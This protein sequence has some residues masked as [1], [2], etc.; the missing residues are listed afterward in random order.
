MRKNSFT[1]IEL[2]VV[3][4]I[5]AILAGMLL[6]A[7][8]KARDKARQATCTSNIK[9]LNL[10]LSMYNG[11][12][13]DR[14]PLWYNNVSANKIY[15]MTRLVHAGYVT[16][17]AILCC[18][19]QDSAGPTYG[20]NAFIANVA[21]VQKTGLTAD[22]FTFSYMSYGCNRDYLFD[23]KTKLTQIKQPSSTLMLMESLRKDLTD[24]RG[25][26]YVRR[27]AARTG[28]Y[29]PAPRHSKSIVTG[30]TDGHVSSEIVPS[31]TNYD[32]VYATNPYNFG[33]EVGHPDNHWDI[34]DSKQPL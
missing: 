25:T 16:S 10:S 31:Q 17:G 34:N 18:P 6:P 11:D 20:K 28:V 14:F 24:G 29:V 23:E 4:A 7:L 15:W 33:D 1:L 12:N 21:R 22:S 2:L 19:N 30:W 5:I 26:S 27:T 32:L 3:I 8:N 9:Q 13:D